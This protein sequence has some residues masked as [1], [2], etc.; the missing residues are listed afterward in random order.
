MTP[1]C[2]FEV[3]FLSDCNFFLCRN[4]I[5]YFQCLHGP[6]EATK[7]RQRPNGVWIV[8]AFVH[9]D[10][11]SSWRVI[12][13]FLPTLTVFL[14]ACI[15]SVWSFWR[16]FPSHVTHNI[17][18][19]SYRGVVIPRR[20]AFIAHSQPLSHACF[21]WLHHAFPT[22]VLSHIERNSPAHTCPSTPLLPCTPLLY[23]ESVL[24]LLRAF[25]VYNL[26]FSS[27]V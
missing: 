3:D 27:L 18:L 15:V 14:P 1:A 23:S 4:L 9:W 8:S 20:A 13:H 7:W 24:N 22:K 19:L 2:F 16:I 17:L 21:L 11:Y 5:Y 12:Q 26:S 6:P 25:D 10:P